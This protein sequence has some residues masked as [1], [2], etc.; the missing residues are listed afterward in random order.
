MEDE[1]GGRHKE[2]VTVHNN[3]DGISVVVVVNGV[4]SFDVPVGAR[5]DG[6]VPSDAE[7]NIC[8][9]Q[10]LVHVAGPLKWRQCY[11]VGNA[12]DGVFVGNSPSPKSY[13]PPRQ[14][15]SFMVG[16]ALM[17][18]VASIVVAIVILFRQRNYQHLHERVLLRPE[19]VVWSQ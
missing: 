11:L 7:Y 18:F 5:R 4:I 13:Q 6:W 19:N 2:T 17:S 8:R 15:I 3:T 16:I 12:S 9:A 14:I 1:K 10:D